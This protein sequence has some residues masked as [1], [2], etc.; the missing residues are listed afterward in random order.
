[1]NVIRQ[2]DKNQRCE[3]AGP[4]GSSLLECFYRRLIVSCQAREG[5]SFR[6]PESQARFAI[7]AVDG[8]AAGIRAQ[9][10]DDVRAIRSVVTVPI[11]G[12]RKL[13]QDDGQV[14]ITPTFEAARELLDAGADMIAMDVTARGRRWGAIERLKR[15]R[16]E[17]K[18]PVLADIATLDDAM[19]AA[20]AGA[21][22]V[23]STMRGYTDDTAHIRAFDSEFIRELVRR[24]P[25]PVI[26]EG[27][28]ETPEQ[29]RAALDA[30]AYAVI[31][32]SAITRPVTIARRFAGALENID[33][34]AGAT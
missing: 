33:G 21:G 15:I 16:A 24:S 30:G 32:G 14:L 6:H 8:G 19:S 10:A 25:V 7:A 18:I 29:A 26:A 3:G 31:V 22:A 28:I 5:E 9:G 4:E 23:L 2:T 11:I 17:L 13:R 12:I 1:L 34:G 27:M 20:E